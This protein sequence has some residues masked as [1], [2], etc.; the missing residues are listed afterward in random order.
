MADL[1]GWTLHSLL[2]EGASP[3]VSFLLAFD[4]F[5]KS[6]GFSLFDQK[7]IIIIKKKDPSLYFF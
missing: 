2:F 7:I 5:I 1:F 3:E 4:D 6:S